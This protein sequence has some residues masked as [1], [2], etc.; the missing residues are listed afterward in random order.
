MVEG[1]NAW[2]KVVVEDVDDVPGIGEFCMDIEVFRMLGV[3][4]GDELLADVVEVSE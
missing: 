4:C 3:P 2:G 1:S